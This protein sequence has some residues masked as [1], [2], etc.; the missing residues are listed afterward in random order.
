MVRVYNSLNL[1]YLGDISLTRSCR[2][3]CRLFFVHTFSFF[4]YTFFT[5]LLDSIYYHSFQ[6]ALF[7]THSNF[8]PRPFGHCSTRCWSRCCR[9]GGSQTLR[10]TPSHLN[11]SSIYLSYPWAYFLH[12]GWTRQRGIPFHCIYSQPSDTR[13]TQQ[14][15]KS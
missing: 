5:L 13:A 1:H 14:R 9:R 6:N 11:T 4:L 8:Y 3:L 12:I 2:F 7:Y 15:G 10:C